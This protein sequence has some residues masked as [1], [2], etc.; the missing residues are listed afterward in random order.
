M[1]LR[2]SHTHIARGPPRSGLIGELN[3]GW[4]QATTTLS[5]ERSG[6]ERPA[7]A[8][9]Y[10]QLLTQFAKETKRNGKPLSEDPCLL[11]TSPSPRDS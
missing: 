9:R 7:V 10:V 6:I 1:S 11:Y 3:R 8:G 5:F 2:H 4:Y